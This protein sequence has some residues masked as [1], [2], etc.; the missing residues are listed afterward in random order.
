MGLGLSLYAFTVCF[1]TNRTPAGLLRVV[2]EERLTG[3]LLVGLLR[4]VDEERLTGLLFAGLL[5]FRVL[6]TGFLLGAFLTTFGIFIYY[7]KYIFFVNIFE[8]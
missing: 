1:F 5:R 4:V 2:D 7:R 6:R 8:S 3:L